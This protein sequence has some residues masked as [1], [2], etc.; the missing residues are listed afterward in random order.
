[1]PNWCTNA[2]TFNHQDPSKISELLAALDYDAEIGVLSDGCDYLLNYLRPLPDGLW[3]YEWCVK[4]W[5]TKWEASII[6]ISANGPNSATVLC[7]TAWTPP[8]EALAYA[9]LNDGFTIRASFIESGA[10]ILG[11][12]D[13][14]DAQYYN[15]PHSADE[16]QNLIEQELPQFMVKDLDLVEEFETQ[17]DYES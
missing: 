17:F 12:Y 10:G 14:G 7:E 1:M 9:E 15:H 11:F 3:D 8:I 2:I 4:S 6:Y 5:G 13:G 16:A